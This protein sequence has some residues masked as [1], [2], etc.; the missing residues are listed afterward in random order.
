MPAY[1][2]TICTYSAALGD[3]KPASGSL[4]TATITSNTAGVQGTTASAPYTF[5]SPTATVGYATVNVTDSVQGTLGST[6]GDFTFEYKDDFA[7]PTDASLY[8]NGVHTFQ[9]PNTATI[10]ETGQSADADVTVTCYAP[11]VTK[12]ATAS[13]DETH[14]WSIVKTVN[15]TS[16]SGIVGDVLPWTWT[17][18][19]SETPTDDNFAVSGT[20]FVKNPSP[21]EPMTV[22]V[23]DTLNDGATATV[24]CGN[25]ST[26]LT[27]AAG[28]TSTCSY[29]ASPT[30]KAATLNTA[31]ATLNGA[32]FSGTAP[33]TFVKNVIGGTA[34]VTDDEIGLDESLTAGEGPWTRTGDDSHTCSTNPDDYGTDGSYSGSVPNT[35]TVVASNEQT[36]ESSATTAY[37]C[38][39]PVVT[40]D[41]TASYD[42]THIWE[43]TK[44][45]NPVSQSGIAGDILPWTWTVVV[46][47]TSTDDNFAVSGTIFVKNPSTEDSMTVNVADTLNDGSDRDS[48]LWERLDQSDGGGG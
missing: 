40:K 19:V 16:Q 28:E 8:T 10:V 4:N 3:T 11:V 26:S 9:V 32:G 18:V 39:A 20:I 37:T 38:Y 42:E 5:G 35:A 44:S 21:D 29:S 43:I 13:Y 17:V 45:V 2:S 15:P 12:D 14:I 22:N 33:V 7:C 47:E 36:D 1:G 27:V 6:S 31:T 24:D 41:A 25:D 34:T 23:A 48:R 46:S 30:G